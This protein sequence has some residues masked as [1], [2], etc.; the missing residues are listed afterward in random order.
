MIHI[1]RPKVDIVGTGQED[2]CLKLLLNFLH[3]LNSGFALY[4]LV[5]VELTPLIIESLGKLNE[6]VVV[7]I[8]PFFWSLIDSHVATSSIL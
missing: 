8:E 3:T 6:L 7:V 5:W 4:Q 2:H 1:D